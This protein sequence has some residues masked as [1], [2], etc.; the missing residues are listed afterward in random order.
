MIADQTRIRRDLHPL[1]PSDETVTDLKILT[2]R[3]MDLSP[4]GT[5]QPSTGWGPS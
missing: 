3:R 1:R 2:G 5:P 4:T